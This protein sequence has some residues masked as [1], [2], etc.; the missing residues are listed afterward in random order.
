MVI[1]A[2]DIFQSQE[3]ITIVYIKHFILVNSYV[4]E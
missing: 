4:D 3:I 2:K 1:K